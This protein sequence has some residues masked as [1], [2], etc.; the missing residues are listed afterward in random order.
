MSLKYKYA[1]SVYLPESFEWLVLSSNLLNDREVREVLNE[2]SEYIESKKYFT[3]EQFFTKVLVDK[4]KD[5]YLQY[6]KNELN[7]IYLQDK[8]L[9][10]IRN[11][12]P[13]IGVL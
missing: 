10:K 1:I 8:N 2:P 5:T 12:M 11:V 7:E 6:N 4:T 13:E 3:W 9:D